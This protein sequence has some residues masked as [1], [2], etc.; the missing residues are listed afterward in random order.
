[1]RCAYF[2]PAIPFLG[3]YPIEIHPST[4]GS[5]NSLVTVRNLH[6][7]SFN[8]ALPQRAE[9]FTAIKKNKDIL[10]MLG[11]KSKI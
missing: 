8:T 1:M 7:M 6:Q 11:N 3:I 9:H 5:Y 2:E 4:Q 10:N